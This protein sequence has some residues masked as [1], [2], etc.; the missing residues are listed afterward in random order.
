VETPEGASLFRPICVGI[1]GGVVFGGG[2]LYQPEKSHT[3]NQK[4]RVEKPQ[5]PST[6]TKMF[7]TL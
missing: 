6:N 2:A 7:N 3:N 4:R 1:G 5:A